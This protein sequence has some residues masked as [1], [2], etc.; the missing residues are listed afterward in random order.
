MP[1]AGKRPPQASASLPRSPRKIKQPIIP[2]VM[3]TADE[4]FA[5]AAADVASPIDGDGDGV[6]DGYGDDDLQ[7]RDMGDAMP[8]C[9]RGPQ[10]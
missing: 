7:R 6:G 2:A 4:D 5:I 10:Q 1:P 8:P 3:Q 9:V